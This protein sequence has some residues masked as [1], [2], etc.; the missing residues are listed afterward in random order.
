MPP[1]VTHAISEFSCLH[2]FCRYLSDLH[3][4]GDPAWQCIGAQHEWILQLMHNCKESYIKEQKGTFWFKEMTLS[5][6]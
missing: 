5:S 3:A 2:Y 1:D 6:T 4:E